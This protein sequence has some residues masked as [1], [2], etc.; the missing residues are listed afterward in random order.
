MI[1]VLLWIFFIAIAAM[2]TP[3]ILRILANNRNRRQQT[4]RYNALVWD[5]GTEQDT[6][7]PE[8]DFALATISSDKSIT[9]V[10]DILA[11]NAATVSPFF[12][13]E[14]VSVC[15]VNSFLIAGNF[16][17]TRQTGN[18]SVLGVTVWEPITERLYAGNRVVQ[19]NEDR[20][21]TLRSV[22]PEDKE[23]DLYIRAFINSF[24]QLIS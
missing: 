23:H 17:G 21:L 8:L 24:K 11:R 5:A 19:Q 3:S 14:T 6:D 12:V 15:S 4:A 10:R 22:F 2:Y 7:Y 18:R 16:T 13:I 1:L 20:S 9:E